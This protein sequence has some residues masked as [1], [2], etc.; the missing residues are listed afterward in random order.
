MV[1]HREALKDQDLGCQDQL[2]NAALTASEWK[3][4]SAIAGRFSSRIA[5]AKMLSKS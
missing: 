1:L 5:A 4:C 2:A 3:T